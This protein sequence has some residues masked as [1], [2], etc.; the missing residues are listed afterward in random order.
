MF[1][2][3]YVENLNLSNIGIGRL[4]SL[5]DQG[6]IVQ[7]SL[8]CFSYLWCDFERWKFEQE[9]LSPV[10]CHIRQ[11]QH[12]GRPSFQI[13]CRAPHGV[14]LHRFILPDHLT[15]LMLASRGSDLLMF[16]IP[17]GEKKRQRCR[18]GI[19]M[20]RKGDRSKLHDILR[21]PEFLI[22]LISPNYLF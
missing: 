17:G 19:E 5:K 3:A 12:L 22:T 7:N 15:L 1:T 10:S 16:F 14:T 20:S 4:H 11:R 18:L 21:H 2:R 6:E 13:L 9:N 8:I